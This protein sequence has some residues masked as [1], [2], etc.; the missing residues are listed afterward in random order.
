MT[1]LS[2]VMGDFFLPVLWRGIYF[3]FVSCA[4]KG[5]IDSAMMSG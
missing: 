4:F 5:H 1:A 3:T 2:I